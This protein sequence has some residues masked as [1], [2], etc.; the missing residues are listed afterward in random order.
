[1]A[2]N[3][4]KPV[5]KTRLEGKKTRMA[6]TKLFALNAN[7]KSSEGLLVG[8]Y[9]RTGWTGAALRTFWWGGFMLNIKKE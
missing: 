7:A 9:L 8:S 2:Q 1:M 3:L 5:Q 6:I 4:F